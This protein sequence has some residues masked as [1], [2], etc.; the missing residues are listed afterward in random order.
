MFELRREAVVKLDCQQIL[1]KDQ[2]NLVILI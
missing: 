2:G 1:L